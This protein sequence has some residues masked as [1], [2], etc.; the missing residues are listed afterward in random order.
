[1]TRSRG[2]LP[3]GDAA[4]YWLVITAADPAIN[5]A[6]FQDS[7]AAGVWCNAVDD[8][9]HCSV[10]FPAVVAGPGH[11]GGVDRRLEPALAS[12]LRRELEGVVAELADVAT[13]G[14]RASAHHANG[15]STEGVDWWPHRGPPRRPAPPE[16][17]PA[18][19]LGADSY[20]SEASELA[21]A[22]Y[23]DVTPSCEWVPI[24]PPS[25]SSRTRDL[26]RTQCRRR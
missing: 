26:I 4:R 13:A 23:G 10:L 1:V 24:D 20:H 9:E 19:P 15:G 21:A 3:P 16:V 6:V 7:E 8:P 25:G 17:V 14:R 11:G 22:L 12:W 2:R 18:A 5:G